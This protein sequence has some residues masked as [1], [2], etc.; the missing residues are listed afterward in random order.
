VYDELRWRAKHF[1]ADERRGNT[2]QTTA[3]IHEAFLQLV[4]EDRKAQWQS[5]SHFFA[6]AARIMRHVLVDYARRKC[7]DKRGG[8][9]P[10]APLEDAAEVS[11]E[12]PA[13]L[14]ALDDAL[15]TLKTLNERA[16]RVVELRYFA[17]LTIEE[18]A[19]ALGIATVTV[20]RD[21]DH[22][23]AWLLCE[24][25]TGKRHDT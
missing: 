10:A 23:K 12:R 5:R 22:A 9:I 17:G 7:A 1:M 2:L 25:T 3:L 21:W 14:V 6:V 4:I 19:E 11:L 8:G 13:E 15:S 18:T 20:K 16:S 24:L